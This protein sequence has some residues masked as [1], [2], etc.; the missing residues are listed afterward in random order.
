MDKKEIA[1]YKKVIFLLNRDI[2]REKDYKKKMQKSQ[3]LKQK[4][5]EILEILPQDAE[6][7]QKLVYVNIN[8]KE[9]EEARKIAYNLYN[10][11][12]QSRDVLTALS[13]IEEKLGN[14][15][16]SIQFI[17]EIL[18]LEPDNEYKKTELERLIE[19]KNNQTKYYEQNEIK[20]ETSKKRY[21]Y[22]QIADLE[23]SIR[24][25]AE[26]EQEQAIMR[27]DNKRYSQIL[28][29]KYKEIYKEITKL[30]QSILSNYPEEVVA[31][32]KLI[33]ALY[34]TGRLKESEE[35]AKELLT[36]KKEDEIALW[37][38]AKIRR[39]QGDLYGEKQYLEEIVAITKSGTQVKIEQRLEKVNKLIE[40]KEEREKL[41]RAKEENCTEET[42]QEYIEQIEKE[43]IQGK[44][45]LQNIDQ[46]IEET[47]KYPNFT[48]SLISLLDIKSKIT[49]N[50]ND[51]IEGLENYIESSYSMTPKEYNQ[52]QTEIATDRDKLEK[53]EQIERIVNRQYNLEN[54]ERS[55]EQR[56]YSKHIIQ[57]LS[58]G[59]ISKEDLP[60]IVN[61]LQT[62]KD[63]GKAIFLI[64]KLYEILYSKEEAYSNLIKYSI[65]LDLSKSEKK[66]FANLQE[67]LM[68]PIQKP[69]ATHKIKEIYKQ[70]QKKEEKKLKRYNKRIQKEEI[71]QMLKERKTVNQ[72][73]LKLRDKGVTLKSIAR[74]KTYYLRQDKELQ[75]EY[76]RLIQYAE[77]FIK[78]GYDIKEVYAIM[79]YDISIP[80]LLEIKRNI[81]ERDGE[82]K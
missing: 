77:N 58:K 78:Q 1:K 29:D 68:E 31:K 19:K 13:I 53:E 39:T 50:I 56:L 40:Q 42:R 41:E 32:E 75:A 36:D 43:F 16:Q 74:I 73:F 5:E 47:K 82:E 11:N 76:G 22:R 34:I 33:K 15:E 65:I 57:E 80:K 35:E 44:I 6:M 38:M 54:Y 63:R 66:E 9:Y 67:M 60:G 20:E 37:Y 27:G 10:N 18:K 61:K 8:L 17:K 46:K 26:K 69:G 24:K 23:R 49:G 59:N 7:L 55:N 81:Q 72:I 71:I 25:I 45:N 30:A 12:I 21:M 70:K 3:Q 2:I 28:D 14:Y 4:L 52:M 64:T 51:K 48:A 79:E 62:F